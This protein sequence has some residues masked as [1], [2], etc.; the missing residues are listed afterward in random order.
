MGRYILCTFVE[1]VGS[2]QVVGFMISMTDGLWFEYI[3]LGYFLKDID[4]HSSG[5]LPNTRVC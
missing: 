2:L 4:F 3:S 1:K 5:I